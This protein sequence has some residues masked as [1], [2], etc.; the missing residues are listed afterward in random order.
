M[1]DV[2]TPQ[3]AV[4]AA[5]CFWGV[6]YYFDQVPGVLE[7]VVGYTGGRVNNPTYDQ[8]CNTDTGH[9]EAVKISFNPEV[10]SFETLL[11]HFFRMHNPTQV[12][13][14]G[15]DIGTQYRSAI[16]YQN[17]KQKQQAEAA[18]KEAQKNWDKPIATRVAVGREFWLAED[19]HQKFTE[20]TGQGMCH[21]PYAP[22]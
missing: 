12:D 22:V 7:T 10:V 4:F 18:I 19:Y 17:D 14:Q 2:F 21:I 16:F 3:T 9:A 1:K 8:V 20:R 15:P 5:G 11:K 6:Q 13:R